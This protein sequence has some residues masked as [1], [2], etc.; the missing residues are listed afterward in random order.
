MRLAPPQHRAYS[1]KVVAGPSTNPEEL[2]VKLSTFKLHIKVT[3]ASQ[4]ALLTLYLQA[5]IAY[6]EKKTRRD[7]VTRT[8]ETF[9]DFFPLP[10]QNEGYYTGGAIPSFSN[11]TTD[12]GNFGFEIRKSPL[13]SIG[14]VEYLQSGVFV[15]VSADVYYNTLEDDYSELLLLDGQDWPDDVDLRM[16]A[17]KITFNSGFGT[18]A[19]VPQELKEAIL[20]IATALYANRGD[21]SESGCKDFT[22]AAAKMILLQNRIENL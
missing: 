22:P 7:F 14:S 1:Y 2:A 4:D 3:S 10:V 13:L 16:Q 11:V 21:C 12:I 15:T 6:A 9:R 8:Y 5:A 17:V 18:E 20:L 19:V